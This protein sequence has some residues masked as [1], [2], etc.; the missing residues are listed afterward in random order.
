MEAVIDLLFEQAVTV[1]DAVA[2]QRQFQRGGGI[3]I[4][5]GQAAKAA[6][7]ERGVLYL[8]QIGEGYALGPHHLVDL[9]RQAEAEQVIEDRAAHQK[10]RGKVK[11]VAR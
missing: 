6:V 10:L 1:A 2:V 5:R 9:F 8:F 3:Q 7:A 4:A 11:R